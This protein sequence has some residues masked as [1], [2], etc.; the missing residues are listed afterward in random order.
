MMDTRN[1]ARVPV[2]L[3]GE[4]LMDDLPSGPVPG[5]APLNVARHLRAFGVDPLLITRVGSDEAGE[6]LVAAMERWGLD[7]RG[8]QRDPDHPTGRVSIRVARGRHRFEI[9]LRQAWD[10]IDAT[11]AADALRTAPPDV[12]YFGTLAQ[13]HETSRRALRGLFAGLSGAH[14]F[15]VNLRKPWYDAQVVEASLAEADVLKLNESELAVLARALGLPKGAAARAETLMERFSIREVVITYGARGARVFEVGGAEMR[16]SGEALGS[17][18][19]D[20]VGAG[21]GFAAVL[22]LGTF[23]GWVPSLTLARADRLARAICRIPGAIPE[24]ERFYEPYLEEW[25]RGGGDD[26]E[27]EKLVHRHAQHP[28]ARSSA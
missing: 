28:R 10:F 19:V 26:P 13:R 4:A 6:G 18:V 23:R 22:I 8:V 24:D 11:A 9:P 14:L 2:A 17:R 20:T 7:T 27:R 15:D 16:V 5:G 21:D 12:L 25:D 1:D 3:F